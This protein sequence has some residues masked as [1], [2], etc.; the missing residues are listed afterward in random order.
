M[1][2][3]PVKRALRNSLILA[4]VVVGIVTYQGAETND[5]LLTGLFTFLATF[6][7]LW[8]SFSYTQ[9]IAEKYRDQDKDSNQP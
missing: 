8:L 6:P 2:M 7:A 3:S 4:F 9:K 1:F 5:A